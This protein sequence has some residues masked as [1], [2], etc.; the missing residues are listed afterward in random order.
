[1]SFEK[2]NIFR[3]W[4]EKY[5]NNAWHGREL[6]G[7]WSLYCKTRKFLIIV[8]F[9]FFITGCGKGIEIEGVQKGKVRT[10]SDE[11]HK[12]EIEEIRKSL[13]SDIRIKLK[14]DGKGSYAWEITGKD[15]QE[16]IRV[17][18]VLKSRVSEEKRE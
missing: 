11:L 10:A 13:K 16:V 6:E 15:A 8:L 18:N 4:S 3:T 14:K 1:M 17:N 12:K 2:S 5:F 7:R 9:L